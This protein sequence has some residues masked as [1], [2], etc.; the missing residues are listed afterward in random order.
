MLSSYKNNLILLKNDLKTYIET[1]SKK[2]KLYSYIYNGIMY[3]SI[4]IGI[5]IGFSFSLSSSFNL[6]K[7]NTS[8]RVVV[9]M[10]SFINSILIAIIKF[11]NFEEISIIHTKATKEYLGLYKAI[12]NQLLNEGED[13]RIFNG[14][15]YQKFDTIYQSS[16]FII[17][18]SLY[19]DDQNMSYDVCSHIGSNTEHQ[20]ATSQNNSI[21][22]SLD[23]D[24]NVKSN[25]SQMMQ[26]ELRRMRNNANK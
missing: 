25:S 4:G 14:W 17:N 11:K 13:Y 26:Y 1:H 16:P 5:F 12:A 19:N 24:N 6:D 9:A 3:S 22:I 20:P 23:D 10:L 21:V 8:F 15:A 7:N 2:S 18:K